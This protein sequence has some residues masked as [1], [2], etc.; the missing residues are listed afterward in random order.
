MTVAECIA[1][2][3]IFPPMT[4]SEVGCDVRRTPNA[5]VGFSAVSVGATDCRRLNFVVV[6]RQ[7]SAIV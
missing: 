3:N 5:S 6:W 2:F 1:T 4:A 7:A